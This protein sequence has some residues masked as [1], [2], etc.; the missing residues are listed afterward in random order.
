MKKV[1]LDS[2]VLVAACGSLT[3]GSAFILG[4]SRKEKIKCFVSRDTINEAKKN[5]F[6]KFDQKAQTRFLFYLKKANLFVVPTPSEEKIADCRK[7]IE[8]KDAPI[9]AAAQ[10]T[11]ISFLLTLDKKHF[12]REKVIK[13]ASPVVITT[14]RDF[15]QKYFP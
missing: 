1:F 7:Y 13:F 11:G 9:L 15:L 14:P 3:G 6:L 10:E 2:S 5:V 4:L 12:L 8:A